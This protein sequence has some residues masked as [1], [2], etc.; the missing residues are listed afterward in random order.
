MQETTNR[1]GLTILGAALALGIVADGLLRA[2]PWGLNVVLFTMAILIAVLIIA[3]YNRT[4][5]T[6]GA[7]W[8]A[9]PVVLFAAVWAWRDAPAVL[10]YSLLALLVTLALFAWRGRTGRL[11]IGGLVDY[12]IGIFYNFGGVRCAR[13]DSS[14]LV[15]LLYC[16]C[17]LCK[18]NKWTRADDSQDT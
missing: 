12:A 6:G 10:A 11:R 1:A 15:R 18:Q 3:R 5:L 7:R 17:T 14:C 16:V 8:I 9:V 2:G 13:V 4:T